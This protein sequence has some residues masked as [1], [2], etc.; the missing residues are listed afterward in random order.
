MGRFS[1]G[2]SPIDLEAPAAWRYS[3]QSVIEL[4]AGG[5]RR[6]W[7]SCLLFGIMGTGRAACGGRCACFPA[8]CHLLHRCLGAFSERKSGC[9]HIPSHHFSGLGIFR[10][11]SPRGIATT[12]LALNGPGAKSRNSRTP[13][14][15]PFCNSSGSLA[16]FAA[17]R[18]AS[19]LVSSLAVDS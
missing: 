13:H 1:F 12:G 2:R 8:F 16:I 14:Q 6:Q 5:R 18:R 15:P 4:R 17:I 19:S 9:R 7:R 11:S 10:S 3:L